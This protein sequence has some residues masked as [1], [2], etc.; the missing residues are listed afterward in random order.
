MQRAGRAGPAAHRGAGG[1]ERLQEPVR[2]QLRAR[3][4]GERGANPYDFSFVLDT[5]APAQRLL[6]APRAVAGASRR[7]MKNIQNQ[8]RG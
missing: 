4:A 2:L 3:A 8:L 5:T 7:K 1:V 6:P